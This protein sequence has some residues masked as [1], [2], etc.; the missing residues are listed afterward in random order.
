MNIAADPL[1]L[2]ERIDQPARNPSGL[3][4]KLAWVVIDLSVFAALILFFG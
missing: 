2:T 3:F 1:L 4:S